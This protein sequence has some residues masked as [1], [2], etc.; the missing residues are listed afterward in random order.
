MGAVDD[1]FGPPDALQ[2]LAEEQV[3]ED[4]DMLA[5]LVRLRKE[6]DLTHAEVGSL[7]GV[8][9]SA[10]QQF[11]RVGGD[12]RLSTIRRYALALGALVRHDIAPDCEPRLD[13]RKSQIAKSMQ[14][15]REIEENPEAQFREM[16]DVVKDRRAEHHLATRR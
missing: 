2:A 8:T 14:Q 1:L 16:L 11:E 4:R 6:R 5:G 10:I 13:A 12:P 3:R 15:P 7:L 9:G